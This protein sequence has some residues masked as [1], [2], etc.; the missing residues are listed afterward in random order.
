MPDQCTRRNIDPLIDV[1]HVAV[2]VKVQL[3]VKLN[4]KPGSYSQIADVTVNRR[5]S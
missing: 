5:N 4:L 1:Q 3:H 2:V